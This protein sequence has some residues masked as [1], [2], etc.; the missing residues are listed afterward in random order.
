[1]QNLN[2]FFDRKIVIVQLIRVYLHQDIHSS[3]D[4]DEN[5]I[6]LGSDERNEKANQKTVLNSSM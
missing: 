3:I 4:L 1:M 5:L 6:N 2:D